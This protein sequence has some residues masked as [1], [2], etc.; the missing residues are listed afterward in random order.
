MCDSIEKHPTQQATQCF[1][2]I[3]LWLNKPERCKEQADLTAKLTAII[4]VKPLY[5]RIYRNNEN[6]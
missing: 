1:D 3:C 5:K 6:S 4:H 2:T